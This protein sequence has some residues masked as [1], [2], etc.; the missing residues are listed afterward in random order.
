MK[1]YARIGRPLAEKFTTKGK[2][3]FFTTL[4]GSGKDYPREGHVTS[5]YLANLYISDEEAANLGKGSLIEIP[6][7]R[8]SSFAK[9]DATYGLRASMSIA[10]WKANEVSY[11]DIDKSESE[12]VGVVTTEPEIK[13][14]RETQEDYVSFRF[15]ENYNKERTNSAWFDV[16]LFNPS[17]EA[18]ELLVKG[19][20]VALIGQPTVRAWEK[21]G[22]PMAS[23]ELKAVDARPFVPKPKAAESAP[24][25]SPAPSPEDKMP[26][27]SDEAPV[28]DFMGAQDANLPF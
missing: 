15:V 27:T 19:K 12:I 4:A 10:A 20:L 22:E 23:L 8:L 3:Y 1:L 17:P 24:A 21:N 5:W 13:T 2:K 26:A 9:N 11:S 7:G 18:M 16:R 14:D 25:E 28:D 6:S